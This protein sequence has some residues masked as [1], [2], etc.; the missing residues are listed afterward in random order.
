MKIYPETICFI[1]ARSGST[2]IKDKNIKKLNKY[3]LIY[4]TVYKAIKSKKFDKIIFSSNSENYFQI[5][6]KYLKKNKLNHKNLI[7]DKREISHSKKKSK[8]F[9]Y[10]KSDLIKKFKF[11]KKDLL[12]QLMPTCPFR[13]LSSIQKAI[14]FSQTNKVNCFSVSEYDFHLSFSF[15]INKNKWIPAFKNSPMITGSTQSQ[16]QK[17]YYHPN[18]VINCLFINTLN[19]NK[20]SIYDNSLPIIVPKIESFDID[21][22]EDFKIL[23][24]ISGDDLLKS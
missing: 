3:P 12:V 14:E 9:D 7:F 15:S 17:K 13:S 19:K 22:E 16:S 2:R 4:W 20:K 1:P 21:T 11:K 6:L 18:G 24:R 8:I 5:L 23:S 10:I